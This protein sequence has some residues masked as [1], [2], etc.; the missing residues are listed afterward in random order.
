[1]KS[2]TIA[3]TLMTP[4]LG[5]SLTACGGAET[6]DGSVT[7]CLRT[8]NSRI[9]SLR[10]L[11]PQ[12]TPC[13]DQQY[14]HWRYLSAL[15]VAAAN[16]LGRW[17]S[18]KDFRQAKRWGPVECRGFGALQDCGNIK[19]I[20]QLQNDETRVIPRHDP[21]LLKYLNSFYDRQVNWNV[22][23]A[24]PSHALSLASVSNDVWVCATT[25]T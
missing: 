22:S 14:D 9:A 24:V 12:S 17:H 16:E 21:G 10:K 19:A 18:A 11:T 20:L 15:A 2:K 5:A 3:S 13:D 25:S 7:I 4:S 23:N 1:M 8:N 6:Y